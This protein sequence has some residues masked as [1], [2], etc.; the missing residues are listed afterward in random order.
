MKPD[1]SFE[2]YKKRLNLKND[3]ISPIYQQGFKIDY[4]RYSLK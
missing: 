4:E 3:I 2:E 1:V